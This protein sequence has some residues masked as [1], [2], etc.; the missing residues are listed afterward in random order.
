VVSLGWNDKY[1]DLLDFYHSS[2]FAVD[3]RV[4]EPQSVVEAVLKK[5]SDWSPEHK[6]LVRV[7]QG[8]L[9]KKV[10]RAGRIC[11]DWIV[12]VTGVDGSKK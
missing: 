1:R 10:D 12:D 11:A 4:G 7:A 3:A 9:R 6:A 8:E 5:A 2:D